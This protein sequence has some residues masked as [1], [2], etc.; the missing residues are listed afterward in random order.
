MQNNTPLLSTNKWTSVQL[1]YMA[2]LADP[3][4]I[5]TDEEIAKYLQVD[6]KT[7]WNW[8]Q[9]D[10][11]TD[12]AYQM[13]LKNLSGKLAKVFSGLIKRASSGDAGAARLILEALN[14]LK[15]QGS[16]DRTLV[17]P[18]Y[19]GQST[20]QIEIEDDRATQ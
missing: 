14:R 5:R 20:K 18:I 10:N 9:L 16:G 8:R 12:D 15:T 7:L 17:I 4:E 13:L 1:Q 3:T 19:G 6:R 11:F 2:I